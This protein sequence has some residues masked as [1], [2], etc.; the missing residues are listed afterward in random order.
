M[1][2]ASS[3]ITS[4]WRPGGRVTFFWAKPLIRLRTTSMPACLLS[5][6]GQGQICQELPLSSLAFNSSTASLYVSPN[7]CLAR[8][9]TEVVLP[10]PGIPEIITCGMLPSLAMILSRSTVSVLPTMSSRKIGR[11]FST[12]NA[13]RNLQ[14]ESLV[15]YHGNSYSGSAPLLLAFKALRAAALEDSASTIVGKWFS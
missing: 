2:S 7:N 5:S 13:I 4:L 9:R 8:H 12:L 6:S 3:K 15:T 1:L 10:M 11:Y 14:Q